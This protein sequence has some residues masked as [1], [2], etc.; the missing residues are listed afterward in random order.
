MKLKNLS[1][2]DRLAIL[3]II[4]AALGYAWAMSR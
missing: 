4:V 1:E 2:Q 3:L